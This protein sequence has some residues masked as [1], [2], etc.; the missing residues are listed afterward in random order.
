MVTIRSA[1][2]EDCALIFSFVQKKS[3]FDRSL[4]AFLGTVQTSPAKIHQT[5]FSDPAF[6]YVLLAAVEPQ[7]IGFALYYF[8]YSSFVGQPS[9]WL[10]DLYVDESM[11]SRGAGS[12][13]MQRLAQI[14]QAHHCSHLA[15]TAHAR[16]L[17][18]LKFY[19]RLGASVTKQEGQTCFLTWKF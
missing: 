16:N 6:A 12:A 19:E 3:E 5:L 13:L 11:R 18:G 7:P 1:T 10:D 9:L 2:P 17:R 4:G 14:A 8:R 15:W